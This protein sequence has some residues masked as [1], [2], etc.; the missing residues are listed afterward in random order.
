MIYLLTIVFMLSLTL[1][2]YLR[3]YALAKNIIDIPNHRS[4]H[5]LPTP[6]GGG[7]GFII[8]LLMVMPVVEYWGMVTLP[9][10]IA[11]GACLIVAALGFLD[12]HGHLPAVV[13]L[14]GHFSASIF[15]L[16][17][18]GGMPSLSF[19]SLII[20]AG[21]LL[22]T[23]GAVYLVW[24]LNLYNFMD[25][26][27]GLAAI[28]AISVC[29]AGA[30][31]YWLNG[32]YEMLGI[33]LILAAAVAGF[34]WWNFPP[35]RIF[36]GD[37][38]SGFLGLILGILTIQAAQVKPQFFWAWLIL[39]GVFIVDATV[40]LLFRLFQGS[41]IYE[42]HCEHA[43]QHATRRFG[44]HIVVTISV[45]FINL[46][47]LFPIALLVDKLILGGVTG[48]FV[49]YLPLIG[50]AIALKAGRKTEQ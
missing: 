12:D 4:S 6:R 49:A 9:V 10:S 19:C 17:W 32:N 39:L 43:Y 44:H 26:I 37:A 30:F 14:V 31:L 23:L 28:E 11:C 22:N 40:T 5:T 1:T 45:L 46:I 16:Y 48:L 20:P 33:P 38:G 3:H 8:T 47:W 35:A 36:M 29:L 25:G 27:D 42:A 15:A 13:R 21:W 2:A 41:K 7:I 34:L 50:L 24:I 18:L